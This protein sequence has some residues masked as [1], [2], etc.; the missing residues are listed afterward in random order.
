MIDLTS[1]RLLTTT[2]LSIG[3]LGLG[4]APL[5][6]LY[7]PVTDEQANNTLAA[8][9]R[10]GIR[11]FDVAPLYGFGLAEARLGRF[12]Q[13][14]QELQH[15]ISTKVGRV[16][17]P[18]DVPPAH[19]Q[20]V[21]PAANR[22]VFDYSRSGIQRSY[23]DSLRRLGVDRVQMLL[24]HDVDRVTH[25]H[26]HRALVTSLLREA[27][28]TLNALKTGG[29]VD[30]IGLGINE[31]DVGYEILMSAEVD[32]VLLA[33]RYTLL[34]TSAFTSGFL[35]ACLRRGVAVLAGGVFNSGFLAGGDHFDYRLADRSR[36]EAR[37][38]L[39]RVC[40]RYS[41]ELPAVALHFSAAHPAIT[42]IVVG[43]RSAQEVEAIFRWSQTEIPAPLWADLRHANLIPPEAPI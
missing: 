1:P 19:D 8:A 35:D 21:A 4:V 29:A 6:N 17:Q 31:W 26:Q 24:L 36:S 38:S 20:F 41:V 18:T 33:G 9:Q 43:A 15:F 37:E 27:I 34:D 32:C 10:L 13:H 12:L 42:S 11:W 2:G 5:G 30:A 16:L 28:P 3:R 40:R 25:P 14:S 23:E 7:A 39:L 22:P